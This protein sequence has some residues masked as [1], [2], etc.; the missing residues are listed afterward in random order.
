MSN[1]KITKDGKYLYS[2]RF[3]V[4]GKNLDL[5]SG[6]DLGSMAGEPRRIAVFMDGSHTIASNPGRKLSKDKTY[7]V[8]I[9]EADLV[10]E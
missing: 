7:T 3:D 5:L 10:E 9:V 2:W 1:L 6:Q 8:L 4:D